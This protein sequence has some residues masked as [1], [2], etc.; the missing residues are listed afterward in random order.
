MF[1][2][3]KKVTSAKTESSP[4]QNSGTIQHSAIRPT[5]GTPHQTNTTKASS[6]P[7]RV[8]NHASESGVDALFESLD[9]GAQNLMET[10]PLKESHQNFRKQ[11]TSYSKTSSLSNNSSASSKGQAQS[12]PHLIQQTSSKGF[13]A[14]NEGNLER[15]EHFFEKSGECAADFFENL[16]SV[17]TQKSN[18]IQKKLSPVQK[19]PVKAI[20]R[21]GDDHSKESKEVGNGSAAGSRKPS[22]HFENSMGN[23][24][25]TVSLP[26]KEEPLKAVRTNADQEKEKE[27]EKTGSLSHQTSQNVKSVNPGKEEPLKHEGDPFEPSKRASQVSEVASHSHRLHE[28]PQIPLY[29]E[30]PGVDFFD[31]LEPGVCVSSDFNPV[32]NQNIPEEPLN[33]EPVSPEFECINGEGERSPGDREE[34]ENDGNL[35]SMTHPTERN[36]LKA[37]DD[38]NSVQGENNSQFYSQNFDND[39]YEIHSNNP[40]GTENWDI[41]LGFSAGPLNLG[42]RGENQNDPGFNLD[43]DSD[44]L[45]K[46]E[47][48]SR[49]QAKTG[50]NEPQICGNELKETENDVDFVEVQDDLATGANIQEKTRTPPHEHGFS[51]ED[52][53]LK[54]GN[55]EPFG[56]EIKRETAKKRERA[57][58]SLKEAQVAIHVSKE[59]SSHFEKQEKEDKSIPVKE[60]VGGQEL[61]TNPHSQEPSDPIKP[62]NSFIPVA[63]RVFNHSHNPVKR[64][65]RPVPAI[66]PLVSSF[67]H[68]QQQAAIAFNANQLEAMGISTSA[69]NSQKAKGLSPASPTH[70]Q[71]P[72]TQ[73]IQPQPLTLKQA[74]PPSQHQDFYQEEKNQMRRSSS[75]VSEDFYEFE[76]RLRGIS[77]MM[78]VGS[79]RLFESFPVE[80]I[81]L[82][83]PVYKYTS[84]KVINEF[85]EASLVFMRSILDSCEGTALDKPHSIDVVLSEVFLEVLQRRDINLLGETHYQFTKREICQYVVSEHKELEGFIEELNRMVEAISQVVN[86]GQFSGG[87]GGLVSSEGIAHSLLLFSLSS[88]NAEFQKK[89][90]ENFIE[91]HPGAK[92]KEAI[93]LALKAKFDLISFGEL[94]RKDCLKILAVVSSLPKE[95]MNES[96]KMAFGQR[97]LE[98]LVSESS[99][100]TSETSLREIALVV[101]MV[102]GVEVN[103]SSVYSVGFKGV[104]FDPFVF[105]LL[106]V[107]LFLFRT[108]KKTTTT[109]PKDLVPVYQKHFVH[110]VYYSAYLVSIGSSTKAQAYLSYGLNYK[111]YFEAAIEG[112]EVMKLAKDL[113]DKITSGK[114]PE[115]VS[116]SQVPSNSGGSSVS[117][118]KL[119]GKAMDSIKTNIDRSLESSSKSQQ[120]NQSSSV[121]EP[122]ASKPYYDKALGRYVFNGSIIEERNPTVSSE[123]IE[124]LDEDEP[125]AP[126]PMMMAQKPKAEMPP[127]P[128]HASDSMPPAFQSTRTALPQNS[129]EAMPQ[130]ETK[131]VS[132]TGGPFA[133]KLMAKKQVTPAYLNKGRYVVKNNQ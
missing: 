93:S 87:N 67:S 50:T 14:E 126:P 129:E 107:Y 131:P 83:P 104:F 61:P 118:F 123:T 94:T 63:P 44:L 11:G 112:K 110:M 128:N 88:D 75:G 84:E 49:G 65:M 116:N 69:P 30:S 37:M 10:G 48:V 35:T 108:A 79:E 96:H 102:Q 103:L 82:Q 53:A 42:K 121:N 45:F 16:G 91:N 74:D 17:N 19:H 36:L 66:R 80:A 33:E 25:E 78:S 32:P 38:H 7:K 15:S 64:P 57:E 12:E 119:F 81:S 52:E 40:I 105:V 113:L 98:Q 109:S 115:S 122:P 59:T 18:L 24:K 3:R 62:P 114:Q 9:N 101:F 58:D 68:S 5:S 99:G 111:Q 86:E 20:P 60:T 51:K 95:V 13:S 97:I 127:K 89:F 70:Q 90:I 133:M 8:L 26:L 34:E 55:N 27:E 4:A 56:A 46:Y 76:A 85:Y 125:I 43:I 117:V 92:G 29:Q 73:A 2:L 1:T 23:E 71:N 120:G 39:Q 132:G 47:P 54:K 100:M 124:R 130:W 6:V 72:R 106:D 28:V 21:I 77:E 41:D 22:N 31:N